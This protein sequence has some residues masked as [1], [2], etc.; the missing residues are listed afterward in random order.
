MKTIYKEINNDY[1]SQKSNTVCTLYNPSGEFVGF[2]TR[3]TAERVEEMRRRTGN[4]NF[5]VNVKVKK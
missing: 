1:Y 2:I 3:N 5:K 4:Y